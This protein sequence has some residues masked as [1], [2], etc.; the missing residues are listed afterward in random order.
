MIWV[1]A[2]LVG[3]AIGLTIRILSAMKIHVL[4]LR[5]K[6]QTKFF[7][8]ANY[9]ADREDISDARLAA[10]SDMAN[11]LGRRR[12]QFLV[13]AAL[14]N[15]ITRKDR[16]KDRS[17]NGYDLNSHLSDDDRITWTKMYLH[18]IFAACAQGTIFG[19]ASVIA[20]LEYFDEDAKSSRVK[21]SRLKLK[22]AKA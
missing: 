19:V 12:T 4:R 5:N 1:F 7:E 13:L 9:L 20:A 18:W 10:L 14:R 22:Y 2:I 8:E 6:Y 21:A 16:P 17:G 3:L 15:A 11:D